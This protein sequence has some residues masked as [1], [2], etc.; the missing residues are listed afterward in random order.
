MSAPED[1][2]AG[3]LAEHTV[4][5]GIR[6]TR[7]HCTCGWQSE[8]RRGLGAHRAHL[9]QVLATY[10]AEREAQ[11]WD[12]CAQYAERWAADV[13]GIHPQ[14]ANPYRTNQEADPGARYLDRLE[15]SR[16]R[17]EVQAVIDR[18]RQENPDE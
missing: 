13:E 6:D 3:I 8:P 4:L 5:S 1:A 17:P 12:A 18:L 11:A 2:L 15:R 7:A 14:R 10:V 9:A 16:P